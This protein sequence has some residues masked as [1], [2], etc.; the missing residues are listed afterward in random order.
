MVITPKTTPFCN[1]VKGVPLQEMPHVFEQGLSSM[2]KGPLQSRGKRK[3]R[4]GVE[5]GGEGD[6]EWGGTREQGK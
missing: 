1:S 2:K 4:K 5:G 6:G 3:G